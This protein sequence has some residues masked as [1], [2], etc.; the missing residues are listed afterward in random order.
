[1][2]KIQTL[3]LLSILIIIPAAQAACE[4]MRLTNYSSHINLN[5]NNFQRLDLE[6]TKGDGTCDHYYITL[7]NGNASS[8][9][10]RSLQSGP[11]LFPVQFYKDS[12][13]TQI[14]KSEFEASASDVLTGSFSGNLHQARSEFFINLNLNENRLVSFGNYAQSYTLK[15]FEGPFG[16]GILR[17]QKIILVSYLQTRFTELSL[18]PIG[19]AFIQSSLSQSLDFGPLKEGS[20]RGFDIV[21]LHNAGYSISISSLN[22]GKL[23]HETKNNYV[24]YDLTIDGSPVSISYL[25][26]IIKIGNGISSPNGT[27]LPVFV[28]I[29]DVSKATA[30]TYTDVITINVASTE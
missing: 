22:D 13:N 10:S 9:Q 26:S 4:N 11:S 1:M 14:L 29:G 25:A 5:T 19:S 15:L 7:D 20:T 18:V 23:K 28:K 2:L 8:S 3:I 30:G 16:Q 17:D 12:S 21:M 24:L 6:I 27:R